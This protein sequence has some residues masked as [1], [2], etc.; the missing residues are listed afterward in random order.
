M[1]CKTILS[2]LLY[3]L[4]C[5]TGRTVGTC[6]LAAP[7][8]ASL[9]APTRPNSWATTYFQWLSKVQGPDEAVGGGQRRKDIQRF[10]ASTDEPLEPPTR[11]PNR[12]PPYWAA[13]AAPSPS[14]DAGPGAI[15]VKFDADAI[16]APSPSFEGVVGDWYVA[17][18]ASVRGL[19]V[20][21]NPNGT[22]GEPSAGLAEQ[23]KR[24]YGD[25]YAEFLDEVKAF[26][27]FS[28]AIWK[29]DPP[30]RDMRISVRFFPIAGKIDQGAGIAFAIAPDG[31]YLD[32]A[33]QRA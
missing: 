9:P 4:N 16:G 14:I 6:I 23:A 1:Y 18:E 17:E 22:A 3:V 30:S 13:S 19:K 12:G 21:N 11:S 5:S 27:Y 32:C 31:S 7:S 24:L 8:R 2:V 26:A 25:R 20:E 28:F 15:T 33:R 10:L 29:G